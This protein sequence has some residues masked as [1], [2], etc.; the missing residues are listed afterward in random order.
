MPTAQA[1]ESIIHHQHPHVERSSA[2][3]NAFLMGS[4]LL[5][6]WVLWSARKLLLKEPHGFSKK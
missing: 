5:L 2:W 4:A 1:H 6:F 3:E